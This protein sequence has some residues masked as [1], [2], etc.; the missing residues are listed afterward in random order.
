MTSLMP[1]ENPHHDAHAQSWLCYPL[2]CHATAVTAHPRSIA[3]RGQRQLMKLKL[4]VWN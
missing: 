1:P 3:L 4:L 2:R